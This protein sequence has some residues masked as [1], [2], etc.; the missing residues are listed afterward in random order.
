[1]VLWMQTQAWCCAL[2][3]LWMQVLPCACD[4]DVDSLSD[5]VSPVVVPLT[6][7]K[8]GDVLAY[9]CPPGYLNQKDVRNA[10]CRGAQWE[11]DTVNPLSCKGANC[12]APGGLISLPHG[13]MSSAVFTFP[14]S[15]TFECNQ[16]YR[17]HSDRGEKLSVQQVKLFCQSD[18]S[19]DGGAPQCKA[20]TCPDPSR[21]MVANAEEI[22]F[23]K[24]EF[25]G[26]VRYR[27]KRNYKLVGPASR[28][29]LD[30]GVW[31]DEKPRCDVVTCSVPTLTYGRV[32]AVAGNMTNALPNEASVLYVCD[33]SNERRTVKCLPGGYWSANPPVCPGPQTSVKPKVTVASSTKQPPVTTSTQRNWQT[34][35]KH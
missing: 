27:C 12:G 32:I 4:C 22:D 3:L 18:G 29:C 10:T 7:F 13:R 9:K 11:L 20:V 17:L 6:T 24:L 5:K 35:E 14:H 2:L 31:S 23:D 1:M 25:G 34:G 28:R 8:E 33:N 16:G 26:E 15:V 30:P 21:D 19:W